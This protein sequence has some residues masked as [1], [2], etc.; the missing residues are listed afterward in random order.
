MSVNLSGTGALSIPDFSENTFTGDLEDTGLFVNRLNH[1]HGR[2]HEPPKRR[3]LEHADPRF[4]ISGVF[5][6]CLC[7]CSAVAG[8]QERVDGILGKS[9]LG[10]A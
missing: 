3:S 7:F 9:R 6:A 5:C 2:N 8:R 4:V 10:G 1:R